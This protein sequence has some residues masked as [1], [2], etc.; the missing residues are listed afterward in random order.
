MKTEISQIIRRQRENKYVFQIESFCIAHQVIKMKSSKLYRST[1]QRPLTVWHGRFQAS[2]IRAKK[3][4]DFVKHGFRN[5]EQ[6]RQDASWTTAWFGIGLAA[7]LSLVSILM[8][9]LS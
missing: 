1:I 2:S 9:V 3:L 7:L 4:M 6:R 8:S 5:V